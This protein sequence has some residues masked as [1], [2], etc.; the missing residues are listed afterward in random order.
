MIVQVCSDVIGL[1][2]LGAG[3]MK[4]KYESTNL[5]V[6][7][8]QIALQTPTPQ[9]G[10]KFYVDNQLHLSPTASTP[11]HNSAAS[12]SSLPWSSSSHLSY[13]YML[14]STRLTQVLLNLI[15]NSLKYT[16]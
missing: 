7:L 12:M 13:Y 14:D 9:A 11:A 8:H 3:N 4:M 2:V 16:S 10:C 6:L 15:G 1:C 5:L